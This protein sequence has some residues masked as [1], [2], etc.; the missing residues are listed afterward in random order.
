MQSAINSLSSKR[1][2]GTIV[3]VAAGNH[4]S[5]FS[6]FTVRS[7]IVS[8]PD[9]LRI[10]GD[11]RAI[12][13]NGYVFGSSWAVPFSPQGLGSGGVGGGIPSSAI[14]T[15]STGQN[16]ITISTFTGVNPNFGIALIVA[17][18]RISVRHNQIIG[19]ARHQIYTIDSV[20]NNEITI[21][22][23]LLGDVNGVG[24]VVVFLPNTTL[25]ITST[26]II[27]THI[28]L[29]GI[30]F[31]TT[32]PIT[33]LSND[34]NTPNIITYRQCVF[35][36]GNSA[37]SITYGGSFTDG[38]SVGFSAINQSQTPI[39]LTVCSLAHLMSSCTIMPSDGVATCLSMRAS[40]ANIFGTK[41]LVS[42]SNANVIN[43]F[44][45]SILAS[46]LSM[47]I[48][49]S[50]NSGT[51]MTFNG[52]A[53]VSLSSPVILGGFSRI[54]NIINS[55]NINFTGLSFSNV[56]PLGINAIDCSNSKLRISFSS[57]NV[58]PNSR[59][60]LADQNSNVLFE[61]TSTIILNSGSVGFQINN[62]STFNYR[63]PSIT[64]NGLTTLFN[65]NNRSVLN[66][67]PTVQ[68]SFT[69]LVNFIISRASNV[70]IFQ[71][72]STVT[73]N[74][75]ELRNSTFDVDAS[76]FIGG[77]NS[78]ILNNTEYNISNINS[79]ALQ[80]HIFSDDLSSGVIVNSTLNAGNIGISL[81]NG[82]RARVISVTNTAI[83]QTVVDATSQII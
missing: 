27:S 68:R 46:D 70:G 19:N 12:V 29:I 2:I 15:G 30:N 59:L 9:L 28:R 53:Y 43:C 64:G 18:D 44:D 25:N 61:G 3:K 74:H 42:A 65:V 55:S 14:I 51:A 26:V 16:K 48:Y 52:A 81:N 77:N 35:Y 11:E 78:I 62:M 45:G 8:Q 47:F 69:G 21:Q 37:I 22:G 67:N 71:S 72:S 34:I 82:S 10:V 39:T 57:I 1:I 36:G 76:I 5:S 80:T 58:T 75:I 7:L 20:S 56:N 63:G 60:I 54:S 6:N 32:S 41:F 17:G 4:T 33:L 31:N 50:Q 40:L 24:A 79:S 83:T 49:N 23:Q 38:Q 73:G 66:I 13:G